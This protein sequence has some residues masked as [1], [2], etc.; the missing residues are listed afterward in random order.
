MIERLWSATIDSFSY[1]NRSVSHEAHVSAFGGPSE[2]YPRVFSSYENAWWSGSYSST[3][4]ERA[5]SFSGLRRQGRFL[6]LLPLSKGPGFKGLLQSRPVRRGAW[7]HLHFKETGPGP[8]FVGF[9]IPKRLV[10]RAV[11]RNL[12][13]RWLNEMVRQISHQDKNA[14]GAYLFRVTQKCPGIAFETRRQTYL[15]LKALVFCERAVQ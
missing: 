5:A 6:G 8:V 4:G 12:I 3:S 7:A 15:D 14:G 2:T 1:Q 9:I 13:R 10:R 11:D